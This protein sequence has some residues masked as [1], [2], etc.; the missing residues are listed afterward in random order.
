MV[1]RDIDL[2]TGEEPGFRDLSGLPHGEL[3]EDEAIAIADAAG[4]GV[5]HV[6][7]VFKQTMPDMGLDDCCWYAGGRPCKGLTNAQ[8]IRLMAEF[9]L[10]DP[11]APPEAVYRHMAARGV[12]FDPAGFHALPLAVRLAYEMFVVTLPRVA[13][14]AVRAAAARRAAEEAAKPQPEGRRYPRI[15]D[16]APRYDRKIWEDE[17][18]SVPAPVVAPP[19]KANGRGARA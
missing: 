4:G 5:F 2:D 15:T 10:A 12:P 19:K 16:P 1:A 7:A 14:E 13:G 17:F 6:L 9:V 11:S 3:T 18:A 8:A